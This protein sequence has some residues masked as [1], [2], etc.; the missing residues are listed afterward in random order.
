MI[1]K[2][3]YYSNLQQMGLKNRIYFINFCLLIVPGT[4][5]LWYFLMLLQT[6]GMDTTKVPGYLPRP[7]RGNNYVFFVD[8]QAY[9]NQTIYVDVVLNGVTEV[10]TM[11]YSNS[12]SDQHDSGPNLAVLTVQKKDKVWVKH[13]SGTGYYTDG[14]L[15]TFSGFL[16]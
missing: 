10:R 7:Q 6:S 11:A 2:S 9:S 14:P 13:Y 3:N 1:T 8:V 15:T 12:G 4:V 16:I 5:V